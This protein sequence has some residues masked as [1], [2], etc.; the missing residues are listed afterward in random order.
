MKKTQLQHVHKIDNLLQL[1]LSLNRVAMVDELPAFILVSFRRFLSSRSTDMSSL[2][3]LPLFRL[4]SIS[5][6]IIYFPT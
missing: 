3:G 5:I 6:L 4:P 1:V 2:L